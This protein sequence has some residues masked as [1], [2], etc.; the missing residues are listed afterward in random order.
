MFVV[1]LMVAVVLLVRIERIKHFLI[2][3]TLALLIGCSSG[4]SGGG[5]STTPQ[6]PDQSVNIFFCELFGLF[7]SGDVICEGIF[8]PPPV[9]QTTPTLSV[10]S[11]RGCDVRVSW[12]PSDI[13]FYTDFKILW[14]EANLAEFGWDN[15]GFVE[16]PVSLGILNWEINLPS[17]GVWLLSMQE[18]HDG[19]YRERGRTSQIEVNCMEA[20]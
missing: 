10:N 14:L 2:A 4:S 9:E 5:T 12:L 15:A 3:L 6:E 19:T 11:T 20:F 13:P 17:S 8:I 16:I 18:K 7:I 1:K